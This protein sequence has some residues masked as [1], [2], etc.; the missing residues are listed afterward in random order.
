[1]LGVVTMCLAACGATIS[2]A[3]LT[4]TTGTAQPEVATAGEPA[5][6]ASTATTRAATTTSTATTSTTAAPTTTTTTLVPTTELELTEV[7]VIHGD[8][9]PKSVVATGNG[10]F[11]A[12]NMMY[13]H[14][15]TVYDRS[16][17]LV[18][19]IAD[20]VDLAAFGIEATGEEYQGSPVE[21][22]V[23]SD[24]SFAYVSN[25]QMYGPGYG[26]AGSDGCGTGDWDESFVYR[27]STDALAVDQV[28]AVGA[29]PKF[30]ALSPDDRL[31]LV[32][33]WCT[34]DLSVIDT[35]LGE[36]TA[37]IAL[38][39]HPRGIA[40]TSDGSLAYVAVM[41]S[42]DVAV[43]D[44][45]SF[46]VEWLRGVGANPRHVV[47][48]PTDRYLYVT[49]NGEGRVAKIDLQTGETVAKIRT[50][51][52]PRSMSISD[53]GRALYVVNYESDTVS[54]VNAE[55]M[56]VVQ[57]LAVPHHPIGITFDRESRQVWVA[58]YSG[59]I[60]VL[61]EGLPGVETEG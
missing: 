45:A 15:V 24:G 59:A 34:H 1:M 37:R 2:D 4:T 42:S 48:D 25:Y 55:T 5:T 31:L 40:V 51:V 27:I 36:E 46:E 35:G 7:A 19:T 18:A 41:G 23:T 22:A 60:T 50:G 28:I 9:S 30:L 58:S 33:N 57:D 6:Q 56:E 12:Q 43:V 38:G 52:A 26:R 39:R 11:F 44:L 14:T 21:A 54:K 53:D 16:F 13:R 8:I 47:L 3:A 20:T 10:L 17:E 29:V 49:L 61:Q 32:T